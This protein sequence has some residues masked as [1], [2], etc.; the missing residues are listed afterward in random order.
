M[1]STTAS[2]PAPATPRAGLAGALARPWPT[3][4]GIAAAAAS[5]AVVAPLPD[6]VQI[7]TSAWCVL[8]AAVIYLT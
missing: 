2:T 4:V 7:W 5:L 8:L 6:A 1:T 3:G